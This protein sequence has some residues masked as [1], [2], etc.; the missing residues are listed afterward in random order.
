MRFFQQR[1]YL[2]LAEKLKRKMTS[3][4]PVSEFPIVVVALQTAKKEGE[5]RDKIERS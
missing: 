5:R 1:W 3:F 4:L 2:F